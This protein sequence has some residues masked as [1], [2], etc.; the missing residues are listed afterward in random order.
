M[1][2]SSDRIHKYMVKGISITSL[3]RYLDEYYSEETSD[4][5]RSKVKDH[6][7]FPI[8]N[9]GW[10]PY[11]LYIEILELIAAECFNGQ[12]SSLEAL[13]EYSSRN[14]LEGIY[15]AFV[16][17]KDFVRFL[18]K[19]SVL[20]KR[21]YNSGD[22]EVRILSDN[23]A[24]I[25]LKGAPEYAEADI[26]IAGGFYA[27]AA[28]VCGHPSAKYEFKRVVNGVRYLVSW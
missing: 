11:E 20:H 27:T 5:I 14:V 15:H 2:D 19:I 26:Y 25:L 17:R 6:D 9:S 18:T 24:E 16:A 21:F 28:K 4:T 1:T 22:M 23:S 7:K 10:Y 3:F 13:G 12:L 8:M